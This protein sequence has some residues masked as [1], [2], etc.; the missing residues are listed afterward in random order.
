MSHW[1]LLER[2][3]HMGRPLSPL[4][5][6]PGV[7][8]HIFKVDWLHAIDQGVGADFIGNLFWVLL[9]KMDGGTQKER[10]RALWMDIKLY[11]DEKDIEDKFQT[12]TVGMIKARGKPPKL[13]GK[14]AEVRALVAYAKKA[15]HQ[16]LDAEDPVEQTVIQMA[17]HLAS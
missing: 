9:G 17:D 7:R 15:A 13:R 5:S 11:Y 2:M 6:A 14:A 12:L 16:Y 3:V 4:L 1:E 10:L 8:N